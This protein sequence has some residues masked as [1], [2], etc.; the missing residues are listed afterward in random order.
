MGL[1]KICVLL[2]VVVLICSEISISAARELGETTSNTDGY[3]YEKGKGHG[4][5]GYGGSYGKKG[6]NYGGSHGDKGYGYGG[7]YGKKG[8]GYGYGKNY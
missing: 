1:S 4:G 3:G 2:A 5:Y 7:S 6:H 8:H